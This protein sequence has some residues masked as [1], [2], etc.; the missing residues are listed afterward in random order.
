MSP[1]LP[2][3]LALAAMAG[4]LVLT[5]SA[6]L[7]PIGTERQFFFD[8]E[9]V[10][11]LVNTKRRLNPAV[12]LADNP[13]IRRD[14]PWEGSD[15][16]LSWVLFDQRLG[17]FRMRYST[18]EYRAGGR[19]AQ[20]EVI[21]LGENDALGAR[22]VT[23]EAFSSDGIHWEKPE[24]GL[25]EFN[26]SKANNILPPSAVH[27]YCFEDLH[28]PDPARRYK[29]FDR[30]GTYQGR[31]M[32]FTLFHSADGYTWLPSSDRPVID[33]GDRAGRWGPTEF[34]GWD[35]I[36]QTYAV[37]MENNFHMHSTQAR[38]SIGRAESP[39]LRHW[40]EPETIISVDD[41]DFPDTEFYHLAATTQDGWYLGLL[42]IFSTTNT[43]HEPHFVFSRDGRR[44][45]RTYREPVIRRGDNGDFDAVSIYAA[46]PI[47]NGDRILCYYTGTNWRSPEQLLALGDRATAGIGLAVLPR[48]G[49]VSLEG[50]RVDF[51]VVTT[52]SF[53]F[54]GKELHLNLQT[55]LQQWG[56]G[57]GEV[58]VELLDSRHV[59]VPGHTLAET[60]PLTATATDA[61]VTWGGHSDLS[62]LAGQPIRL[63]I[64]F[65]NAKLY[66]FQFR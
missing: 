15:L 34:L 25:V 46:R 13:V 41:L 49:F 18:G 22:R 55:A 26:G 38:R 19:N 3:H 44:Y 4:A 64:H 17:K 5:A 23:C 21:V 24:L 31:G 43:Q 30:Q 6:A 65:R 11:T 45:D 61:V 16:R 37:H 9:I 54:A 48:D 59:P 66:S 7:R 52:R 62:A 32:T 28:D 57:P 63:R 12:K 33:T 39:D 47:L 58:R 2:Y 50:G 1:R 60:D 53:T 36:R 29:A 51:S 40:S 56:A 35:P 8:D 10:E 27:G 42:W 20:G 14:K